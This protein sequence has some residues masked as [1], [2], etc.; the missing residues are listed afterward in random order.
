MNALKVVLLMVCVAA[1]SWGCEP[2]PDDLKLFDQFVVSTNRDA[3][4][5][6]G[7]YL[8][9]FMQSDTIGLVSNIPNDDTI[10]VGSYYARPVVNQVKSNL[11]AR[12]YQ[13]VDSDENPDLAVKAYVVK[14]LN[15]FQD[16]VYPPGYYYPGYGY[17][18]Y[19]YYPPYVQ[20]YAYNTGVLVVEII[21]L[22]N[23]TPQNE[24]AV[25][26]TAHLGDVFSSVDLVQQT[27]EAI[28]QAFQQS[29][30]ITRQ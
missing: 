14:D 21:D 29:T 6:F 22:K 27:I 23:I 26:W 13:S 19:Y 4:A 25:I 8:T 16:Y 5:D 12:G 1:M 9:Y 24:V 30:Y 7:S 17:Y 28:D 18:S 10:I 2:Q 3:N 11:N 15:I 20:T